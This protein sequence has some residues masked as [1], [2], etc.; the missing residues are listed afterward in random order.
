[1]AE[2][3][4]L[5]FYM[6]RSSWETIKRIIRAY[7]AVEDKETP[8]V[9]EI[10]RLGNLQRPVVS[11]SNMFLRS[12]GIIRP[13]QNKLTPL[14]SRI[15]KG[16]SLD[17]QTVVR[18]ALQDVVRGNETLNQLVST[19]QARGPMK[20]EAFKG[21]AIVLTGLNEKKDLASF[22]SILDLLD[23]S[24]VVR[25]ADDE[26]SFRGYYIG[27]IKGQANRPASVQRFPRLGSSE[28][29]RAN[30]QESGEGTRMPVPLGPGRLAYLE[31]PPDWKRE[32]LPKL[33]KLLQISLGD[34]L[35]LDKERG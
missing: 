6:P 3:K 22:R 7:H 25:I 34:D 30:N 32:E 28:E 17:N 24:Q 29:T 21:Q 23:E 11:A 31:L 12:F 26:V 20:M 13:D 33:I 19:V 5:T 9:E 4:K 16:L 27:E 10:A 35:G 1:M 8:T 15:A 2:N 14:G 18:E